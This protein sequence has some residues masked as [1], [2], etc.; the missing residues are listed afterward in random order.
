MSVNSLTAICSFLRQHLGSSGP[1][2]ADVEALKLEVTDLR[3]KVEKLSEENAEL[4][5]KVC[6]LCLFCFD[7][8]RLFTSIHCYCATVNSEKL[9]LLADLCDSA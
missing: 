7:V 1:E 5:Q 3:Q 6:D 2:T 4:K 8:V 9:S